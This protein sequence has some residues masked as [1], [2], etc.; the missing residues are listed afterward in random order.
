MHGCLQPFEDSSQTLPEATIILINRGW[1]QFE[2]EITISMRLPRAQRGHR[3]SIKS[4]DSPVVNGR[5]K[6]AGK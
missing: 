2:T 6:G 1:F 4:F 5:I 3:G